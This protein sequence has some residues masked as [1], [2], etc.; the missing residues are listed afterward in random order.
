[1]VYIHAMAVTALSV[2]PG[3]AML[4]GWRRLRLAVGVSTLFGALNAVPPSAMPPLHV[5][6]A[7]AIPIGLATVIAFGLLE[8]YPARLP[9]WLPRWTAQLIGVFLAGPIGVVLPHLVSM[10]IDE[11]A[12]HGPAQM[13]MLVRSL[14]E[15]LLFAPWIALG[16][17]VRQ[18]DVLAR[19]QALAFAL[20][21]SQLERNALETRLRLLQAQVEPHS[22]STRSPTCRSSSTRA[23]RKPPKSS[24]A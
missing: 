14:I 23:R 4:F 17:M 10:A 1:L 2:R 24:R 3:I 12:A 22:C 15:G 11:H 8:R 16:A 20:E 9:T 7:H 13:Q 19:D 5:T 6:I 18:R 21:R